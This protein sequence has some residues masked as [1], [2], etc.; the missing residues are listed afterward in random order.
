MRHLPRSRRLGRTSAAA[1]AVLALAVGA[2]G[3]DDA[4]GQTDKAHEFVPL[5]GSPRVPDDAGTVV[6]VADDFSTLAL[7]GDRV[8]EIDER[9]QAFAAATGSIEPVRE[10]VGQYVQVGTDGDTVQW[11]GRIS[12]VAAQ[13]DGR[14]LAYYVGVATEVDDRQVTFREGTV[15][16]LADGV[17]L[18]GP[19]PVAVTAT[20]DVTTNVVTAAEPG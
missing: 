4:G 16:E 8:F 13:P 18:P 1:L 11:I 7:D 2:C 12:A 3:D 6:A 10:F 20:I 5:D 14:K 9:L 15:L 17:E 19:V